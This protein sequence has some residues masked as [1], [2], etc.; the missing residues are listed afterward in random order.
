MILTITEP[1]VE[2]D[3]NYLQQIADQNP[4]IIVSRPRLS[5]HH[6][7]SIATQQSTIISY[8]PAIPQAQQLRHWFDQI[9]I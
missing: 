3:G 8:H 7:I 4:V 6:G 5:R 9:P 2:T 1:V